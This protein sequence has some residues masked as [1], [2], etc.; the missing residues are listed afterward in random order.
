VNGTPGYEE[1]A[2]LGLWAG[3][4]AACA[5]QGRA[6]FL[7]DRAECYLAVLVDDLVTRG[8]IEPYRMFTSRAEYRLLLREDNADLRL[9]AHGARLGL[10]SAERCRAVEERG[11]RIDG[12]MERLRGRRRDGV[13]LFQLLSRPEATYAHVSAEDPDALRDPALARQVEIAVKYDGYIRRMREEIARFRASENVAIPAAIDYATVPGLSTEARQ[14]LEEVR[15]RSLGQA[16]RVPGI[17][18][19][20]LSILSVWTHRLRTSEGSD[21]R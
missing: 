18:P 17:T 21:R 5:V 1:A 8:T 6:P 13:P 7:P 16:S 12:E 9:A 14:R 10:V 3:V 4:N 11:A 19:A 15:P 20:A 2:A